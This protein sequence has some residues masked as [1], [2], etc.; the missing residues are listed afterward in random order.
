MV[1]DQ[2]PVD[3]VGQPPFQAAKG[4][5]LAFAGGDLLRVVGAAA[6]VVAFV[7]QRDDVQGVVELA[8]PG[9]RQPVSFDLAGGHLDRA[10]PQKEA[11]AAADGNRLI[12][13]VRARMLAASTSPT[14]SS[15]VR[16]VPV[17]ATPTRNV[18]RRQPAG[19][20]DGGG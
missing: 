15:R 16:V 3:A 20:K 8:V 6:G 2:M 17:A 12:G 5:L 7:G 11:N 1:V 18:R 19:S 10:T 14:P 13:P 4:T 9:P